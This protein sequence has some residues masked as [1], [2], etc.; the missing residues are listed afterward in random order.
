MTVASD[1]AAIIIAALPHGLTRRLQ[2]EGRKQGYG[3]SGALLRRCEIAER[4]EAAIGPAAVY[5]AAFAGDEADGPRADMQYHVCTPS[6]T[7][8]R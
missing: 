5:A 6:P 1:T 2:A 3:I 4:V 8:R 7:K